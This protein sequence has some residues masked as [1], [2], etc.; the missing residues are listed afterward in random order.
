MMRFE[1]IAGSR[2]KRVIHGDTYLGE[3]HIEAAIRLDGRRPYFWRAI[4]LYAPLG[5]HEAGRAISE[6][7]STD[8]GNLADAKATI[9]AWVEEHAHLIRKD[10]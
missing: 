7:K 2:T 8:L 9:T 10:K 3:L 1:N 4:N 6:I 5:D